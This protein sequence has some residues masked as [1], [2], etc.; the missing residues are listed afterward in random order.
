MITQRSGCSL[1][2]LVEN[3][4]A[5]IGSVQWFTPCSFLACT[6]DVVNF[7][8]KFDKMG[9][10]DIKQVDRNNGNEIKCDF[11]LIYE[12]SI[13]VFSSRGVYFAE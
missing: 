5:K 11:C 9:W 8:L 13:S 10:A 4:V 1:R 6:Q 7:L 2:E 12:C 3:S